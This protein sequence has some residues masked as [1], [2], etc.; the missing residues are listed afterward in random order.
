MWAGILYIPADE[1]QDGVAED[2]AIV[3][4]YQRDRLFTIGGAPE[5]LPQ[6]LHILRLAT[7]DSALA[8]PRCRSCGHE[9]DAPDLD[10]LEDRCSSA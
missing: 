8:L 6:I 1:R 5:S 2:L 9:L 10:A 4:V 7:Y 3:H